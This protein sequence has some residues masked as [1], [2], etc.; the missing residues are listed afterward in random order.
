MVTNLANGLWGATSNTFPLPKYFISNT[1]PFY[2]DASAVSWPLNFLDWDISNFLHNLTPTQLQVLL[3]Y[4]DI[5]MYNCC[6]LAQ[7]VLVST[8]TC[9]SIFSM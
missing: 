7:G 2:D 9:V 4:V 5:Y 6:V 3:P 8:R 1:H